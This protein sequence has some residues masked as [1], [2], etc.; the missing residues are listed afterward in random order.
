MFLESVCFGKCSI[1]FYFTHHLVLV[2][3]PVRSDVELE[4]IVLKTLLF[5]LSLDRR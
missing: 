4:T 5:D 3:C 2:T 1:G